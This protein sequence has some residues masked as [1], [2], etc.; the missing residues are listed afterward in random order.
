M[1]EVHAILSAS[2]SKRWLNCT[3][4][5]RLEQNF[6]NESSVYA[7]PSADPKPSAEPT[8]PAEPPA[9]LGPVLDMD[10]KTEDG[11]IPYNILM[12]ISRRSRMKP[13]LP[14]QKRISRWQSPMQRRKPRRLPL[15]Q[16]HRQRQT[17]NWQKACPIR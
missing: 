13:P 8:P 6:P 9:N 16:K 4:S 11:S 2:S 14:R 7:E 1:P 15:P 3:P 5:A 12:Q 10:G 17:A